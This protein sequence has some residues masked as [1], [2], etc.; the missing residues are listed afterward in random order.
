MV[1]C[2]GGNVSRKEQQKALKSTP[3]HAL[4]KERRQGRIKENV[5]FLGMLNWHLSVGFATKVIIHLRQSGKEKLVL[6]R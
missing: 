1:S 5:V 4:E 6:V 2:S 3:V